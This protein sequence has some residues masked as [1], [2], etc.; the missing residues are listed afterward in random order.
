MVSDTN[1]SNADSNSVISPFGELSVHLS[2]SE[3]RE[4]AFEIFVAASRSAKAGRTLNYVS[5]S[6][7]S[8]GKK[9]WAKNLV[10]SQQNSRAVS[11]GEV[12][13]VQMRISEEFDSRVR[14]ALL[15]ITAG[16]LGRRMES[17]VLPLE[18]L[19]QLKASDFSSVREYEASQKRILK[20]LEAGVLQHP[21]MP[22]DKTNAAARKLREIIQGGLERPIDTGRHSETM[23]ALWNNVMS[24]ACRSFDGSVSDICHWADG[25]PLN[26]R[27][28][29]TLLESCFDIN[30]ATSVVEEADELLELIK[31]TWGIL[32]INL[33]YHNLCL[34]W[35]LYDRYV[36][37][38]EVE[39]DLL[40]AAHKLFLEVEKD[41][42][43]T[44]DPAYFKILSSALSSVLSWA[45][46][47]FTAY[48]E[49]FYRGNID[50]M[51]TAL[52][53]ISLANNIL[54]EDMSHEYGRES[55][56]V[57][58]SRDRIDNYIRSSMRSAFIQ[59]KEKIYLSRR[60][61]SHQQNA[62]PVLS[63]LVQDTCDLA[64]NEKEIY[65]PL[66]KRWHP[67]ATG[68]A[69]ATLHACYAKELKQFVS[70][71]SELTPD[72][73]QVLIAADKL[74]K[75]LVQMAVEDSVDSEDGG[76]SI[77]QE[78]TPYEAEVV[79]TSLVKSWIRTR[80]DRL[81]E[82][83]VRN[84]QQEVWN[85]QA[86]KE[87]FAPSAV[88]VLRIADETLEAFFLLPILRHP[89]LLPDLMS[90]LD[91]CLQ[92]YILTT[93]SGCGSQGKFLPDIPDLTRC[94]AGSKLQAVFR[95]KDMLV[96]RRKPRVGV[97]NEEDNMGIPQ[98]CVRI[99]TLHHIRKDLDILENRMI[100]HLRNAGYTQSNDMGKIFNLSQTACLEGVQQLCVAT[101]YKVIFHDLSPVF[102]DG[103]YVGEVSSSRIEPFLQD[104][105][106][107]LEIMSS[108]VHD[109]VRTRLIA[110]VM[111]ASLDGFLLVL[112]AGGP[113]R[114]YSVEDS[115]M[116]EED[117]NFLTDL[118]WS[119]GNGLQTELIDKFAVTVKRILPLLYMDTQS[120]I[121][122]F[123]TSILNVYGSSA[124]FKLPL[125]LTSGQWNPAE[126]STILH[127][128]CHRN[129]KQATNFLKKTYNLPK[130]L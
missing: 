106:Q 73:I 66:L 3:L 29:Q 93:V 98:L 21:H 50:V 30:K 80:I 61:S 38:G 57:D 31:K 33:A 35:V 8:P 117:F 109:R 68:V 22:L 16:Q 2:D 19:Q 71:I 56:K 107:Y 112:L 25:V 48:H 47:K 41:A 4:T 45:D 28:Y 86:N 23:Q 5:S 6:S 69:V 91:K 62:L 17:L 7:Y 18:L 65:S 83:V 27:L 20:V 87:R 14:R 110:D 11:M 46:R 108:I 32:G 40:N 58:I 74:E 44:K 101:A 114:A 126:P 63:I 92:Y 113:S 127:V 10:G 54:V 37:T 94:T 76:I 122:Q 77:I 79:I 90:S 12:M 34:S 52:S 121:E 123:R 43:G 53:L 42:K 89:A 75:N 39:N 84:L 128:L 60:S 67:L 99:N 1:A 96:Q 102:W 13:R 118:F 78:M 97:I 125:P 95:K 15:R 51:E 26:L 49:T 124:T 119:N 103:L 105:E 115:I 88:E 9:V 24:L 111:K 36:A 100:T 130:K 85:P 129:D 70:G 55:R 72:A 116:I 59:K 64:F 82:W 120:L 81:K 104:L